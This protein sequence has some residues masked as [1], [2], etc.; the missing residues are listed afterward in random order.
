MPEGE[1]GVLLKT[2]SDAGKEADKRAKVE[3]AKSKGRFQ[4]IEN[5][6][7]ARAPKSQVRGSASYFTRK[8]VQDLLSSQEDFSSRALK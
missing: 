2:D 4:I 7:K 6:D 1:H 5:E 8:S 3:K